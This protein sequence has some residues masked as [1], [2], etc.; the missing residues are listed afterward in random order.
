MGKDCYSQNTQPTEPSLDMKC[1]C[2]LISLL[3]SVYA[4]SVPTEEVCPPWFLYNSNITII[5][6]PQQ[7]SHCVCGEPL[8]LQI[9][10]NKNDYTSSL[11]S[12]NCVFRDNRTGRTL[13]G[14]CP[15]VF[16]QHLLVGHAIK[17][18][19]EVH[20]LNSWFCSHLNRE[21]HSTG[22][23]GCTNGT[24]PSVSSLG[25][26]CTQCS[27]VNILYYILLHYLPP[28]IIFFFILLVQVNVTSPP[29]VYY[30]LYSN[31]W[32][33]YLETP[34]GYSM[35]SRVITGKYKYAV[36][37]FLSLHSIRSFD[38][39]N[40]I[41][42]PLCISSHLD[43][44][45]AQYF[46]MLKPLYPFMLLLVAYVG[47]ELHA[48]DFKPVVMCWRPIFRNLTRLRKTWNPHVSLVQAFATIF[49][50]KAFVIGL[51]ALHFRRVYR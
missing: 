46:V 9:M 14:H 40:F 24:G 17:L 23:G 31:A 41:S 33:V 3:V 28:T 12:G 6:A 19:Q 45:D 39:L 13:V 34:D 50:L 36:Q 37:A 27:Q 49:I 16:P 25:S 10:C 2:L 18:P 51:C 38:P 30:V 4:A 15:Y 22:C 20:T 48:R 42:P 21:T 26:Q 11:I 35:Y 32:G 7:Y 44:I 5:S 43:D 8:L 29:M 1:S 47:I